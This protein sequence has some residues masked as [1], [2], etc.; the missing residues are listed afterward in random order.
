LGE[1]RRT[2]E[3]GKA[4]AHHDHVGDLQDEPAPASWSECRRN[5]SAEFTRKEL[6]EVM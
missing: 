4:A 1:R 6:A 2:G 3:A 5:V